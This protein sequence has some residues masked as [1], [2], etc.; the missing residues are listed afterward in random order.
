[1]YRKRY[2]LL[3]LVMGVEIERKYVVNKSIWDDTGKGDR[4]FIRQG[5]NL[6]NPDKT[7]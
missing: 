3:K 2:T 7:M 1:M 6:N 4:N 5:Y